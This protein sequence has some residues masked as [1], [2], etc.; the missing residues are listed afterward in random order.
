MVLF[1]TTVRSAP[2][3][4]RKRHLP[5]PRQ[6]RS[7]QL[8]RELEPTAELG[9]LLDT[10]LPTVEGTLPE[11]VVPDTAQGVLSVALSSPAVAD[12][13]RLLDR[14]SAA[15]LLSD[16]TALGVVHVLLPFRH[17]DMALLA[18]AILLAMWGNGLYRSRLTLSVLDDLPVICL[19]VVLATGFVTAL[20]VSMAGHDPAA[21]VRTGTLAL[22]L[23]VL[24]R[25]VAYAVI[26][27]ARARGIVTYRTVIM[28]TGPTAAQLGRILEEHPETGL[29]VVGYVGPMPEAS[30]RVSGMLLAECCTDLPRVTVEHRTPVVLATLSGVSAED[31]LAGIRGRDPRR[32]C[33]LFVVPPLFEVL[34]TPRAERVFHVPLIRLRPSVLAALPLRV[35]R[36]CDFVLAAVG[37]VI[38]GPVMAAVAFAVRLETGRGVLFRQERVGQNGE[39]F[40][41]LKFRSLRPATAQESGRLWSVSDDERMGPVGRFI[42]KTSLDEL[43][44]LVNVLRGHMSIIGPRPERPY[45]V[46]QFGRE[47]GCYTLR[48]RVRPGLTGWAAVN[49]LRGDTSI[50]DR[51]C[52]D[53]AYIDNWSLWLD[54]KIVFRTVAAVVAGRGG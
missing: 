9:G 32:P 26:R 41:L 35:K 6:R 21:C 46:E 4:A 33:T 25:V 47:Y 27:W 10:E 45:F 34:H 3:H 22:G 20:L 16:L 42:R 48:H 37:L 53:N 18:V 8:P 39:L 14:V 17:L 1:P 7:Q 24:G 31:V 40:T 15:L 36:L 43:P 49:G 5:F 12:R 52:F 2:T 50:E 51:V 13:G 30:P 54:V 38:A 19:A 44:Q 11:T 29:R 28:G 23:V